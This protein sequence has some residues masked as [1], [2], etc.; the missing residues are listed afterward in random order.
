MAAEDGNS[1][2][3]SRSRRHPWRWPS[4]GRSREAPPSCD[5]R[6]ESRSRRAA[7]PSGDSFSRARASR[8]GR[9]PVRTSRHRPSGESRRSRAVLSQMGEPR[10]QR[11]GMFLGAAQ[12]LRGPASASSTGS[13]SSRTQSRKSVATWSL[14]ERAVCSRR[15]GSS[16]SAAA[17]RY[18]YEY[19]RAPPKRRMSRRRSRRRWCPARHGWRR[20]R[21]LK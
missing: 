15:A 8:S 13:M 18:S 4:A 5:G 3:K 21:P 16:S 7:A 20:G 1:S 2:A 12:Q 17:T 10:H 9:D 14:R 11:A 6:S 19:P